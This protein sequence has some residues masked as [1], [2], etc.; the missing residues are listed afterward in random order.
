[1]ARRSLGR[2]LGHPA[3]WIT[4]LA[5]LF[6][7]PLTA[8]STLSTAPDSATVIPGARFRAGPLY[9]FLFGREYRSLWTSPVRVEVLDLDH[10]AGGLTPT[11]RG[12]G[13]QTKSLRFQA[14]DGREYVFRS[15]EKDP[16]TVLPELKETFAGHVIRDQSKSH[17]PSAPM[18]VAPLL[19]AVQVLHANPRLVVMPDDA[20]LGEFR[21]EFAGM[22]GFLEERPNESPEGEPGFGGALQVVGTE[23]LLERV[24]A[25]PEERVD[26]RAFLA[27]RLMDLLLGDWDRHRDQ[28]RWALLERDGQRRWYPIPRDRDQAFV[29]FDGVLLSIARLQYPKVVLFDD[30]YGNLYGLTQSAQPLDRR[31]LS[32]LERPAWDSVVAQLQAALTDEV[33]RDAVERMPPEHFARTGATMIR[34]LQARRDRLGEA[35]SWLYRTLAREVDVHATDLA[36]VAEVIRLPRRE[37]E[38]RLSRRGADG[39]PADE[40]YYRRRFRHEETREVRIYLHGGADSAL[41]HG[42]EVHS[43]L[44][45]LIGGDGAD[46]LVDGSRVAGPGSST[47]F[48]D[49]R[50]D[51][52]FVTGAEASVDTRPYTPPAYERSRVREPHRD[53]GG[54]RFVTPWIGYGSTLGLVLGGGPT[55]YRYGFRQVPYASRISLRAAYATGLERGALEFSGSFYRPNSPVELA[56]QARVSGIERTHYFGYGNDAPA[57]EAST[58]YGVRQNEVLFEPALR[59]P[60][61]KRLH[62]STGLVVQHV[63]TDTTAQTL[64]GRERPYGSGPFGQLGLRAALDLDTR[65]HPVAARRGVHLLLGGTLFPGVWDVAETFGEA[66]LEASTYLSAELPGRPTLALRAGG[67]RIW[68]EA[69]FNE[70]AFVGGSRTLRGYPQARFAGDAAAYGTAELRFALSRFDLLFPGRLGALLLGDAGR[71]YLDGRS[72]GGWHTAYGGGLWFYFLDPGFTFRATAARGEEET[73]LYVGAGFLF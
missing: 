4:A 41:V 11:R 6:A 25:R 51:S 1:M 43:I 69:P 22:L 70:A 18:V 46:V 66:H 68:G 42:A 24:S 54:R 53:W 2:P 12:G 20:R 71:A 45:R 47:R 72:P 9:S 40:P 60:L 33:I 62:G 55:F 13:N 65:D 3:V 32:E 38:V 52:R 73:R 64:I 26:A 15:V 30:E 8:Q 23:R 29:K 35:A 39:A 49:S 28:W 21:A 67:K 5:A 34:A 63:E 59:F 14:R 61:L 16:S 10:F 31:F 17:H 50:A 19:S 36:E 57:P 58:F 48:Y 37:L 7:S 44:V 56:L 27:A